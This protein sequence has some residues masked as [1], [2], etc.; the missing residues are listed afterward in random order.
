[1]GIDLVNNTVIVVKAID[2]L[3]VKHLEAKEG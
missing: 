1:M 3:Y 2:G